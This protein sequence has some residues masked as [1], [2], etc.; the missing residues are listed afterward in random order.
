MSTNLSRRALLGATLAVAAIPLLGSGRPL[1]G[2]PFTLGVASGEPAPDGVVIWTR[3]APVPLADDGLGGMPRRVV[4]VEWEVATDERFHRIEQRGM[5][6]ATPES[7]HTVHVELVGLAPAAEYFYRFRTGGYLSA[8]GR[9]RTAPA[10][11]ASAALTMCFASCSNFEQ[12]WFTGYRRLAEDHPDLVVHLGD[13][14]Y[15]TVARD[16]AVRRHVG[17]ETVTLAHYRQRMAQYRTDPDLQ[18][19]HAVAPWLVV[20]D[21]HELDNN[22]AADV[23]ESPQSDFP[24]RRAAAMQ[25]YHENMPLR[26]SA[27]PRGTGMQLYR[28]VQWGALATFHMLDTRQY[29]TDQACGDV[30]DADCPELHS[31]GR[32]LTGPDQERWLLEGLRGSRARWDILGQQVFFAPLDVLAGP[33]RGVNADAWDGYGACRE[34]ITAGLADVRNAVVLTGDVHSHWAAEISDPRSG[35]VATELVT[36]SISSGGDGSDSRPDVEAI[37]PENPHIKYFSNR[38]GYVRTR[39]TADELRAE[40]RTLPFVTRPG[41][42]ARTDATFVIA[43]RAPVLT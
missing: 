33:R 18:A 27:R 8:T 13:Y 2:D 23:P 37:L 32:T 30:Y 41:A 16:G 24:A 9:T 22:W 14:Q 34:R 12:G 19:A 35:P 7:A 31:P 11:D 3:L 39:I 1:A 4:D 43:D 26:S 40:F 21:D 5:V 38:R 42:P 10:P 17:P 36:T 28:R 25:A 15:E 6:S 29:R 20:F